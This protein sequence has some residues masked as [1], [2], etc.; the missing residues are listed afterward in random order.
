MLDNDQRSCVGKCVN[1][2]LQVK[3]LRNNVFLFQS[4]EATGVQKTTCVTMKMAS[5]P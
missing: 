3:Q 5:V 1:A 2:A 4:L